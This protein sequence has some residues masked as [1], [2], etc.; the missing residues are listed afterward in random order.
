MREVVQIE[1][2]HR[3]QHGNVDAAASIRFCAFVQSAQNA[4]RRVHSRHRVSNCRTYDTRVLWVDEK[5]KPTARRLRNSV[6][7]GTIAIRPFMTEARDAAT[8]EP[9]IELLKTLCAD[10]YFLRDTRPKILDEY[11][12]V[13][14][15]G[16]E[17]AGLRRR[18]RACG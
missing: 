10:V 14:R 7:S 4:E 13:R 17:Y 12:R 3:F 8:D 11:V 9:R 16:V 2:A 6:I 15:Q 5:P 1:V 18:L